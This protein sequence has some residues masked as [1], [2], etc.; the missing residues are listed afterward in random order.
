[1][2][3]T[4]WSMVKAVGDQS[5]YVTAITAHLRQTLPLLRDN[6]A[7]SRRYFTQ[8]CVHFAR[9]YYGVQEGHTRR[10]D[11]F[12]RVA[13]TGDVYTIKRQERG[14]LGIECYESRAQT[15]HKGI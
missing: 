5:G 14:I 8:F 11:A 15:I 13:G 10:S 12:F 4:H 1:M 9:Y 6:L 2:V 3:Q 7:N